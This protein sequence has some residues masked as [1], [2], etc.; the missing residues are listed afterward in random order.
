MNDFMQKGEHVASLWK[1]GER[2]DKSMSGVDRE[3][4]EILRQLFEI[5]Q[6][7]NG[8]AAPEYEVERGWRKMRLRLGYL[9]LRV[10]AKYVAVFFFVSLGMYFIIPYALVE[11]NRVE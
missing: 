1:K 8:V 6:A 11:E 3:E 7:M 2:G 5:R 4:K 10:I 9:R